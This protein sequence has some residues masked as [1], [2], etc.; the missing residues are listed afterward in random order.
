MMIC[1]TC[2]TARN[3]CDHE[4]LREVPRNWRIPR[5]TNLLA[6]RRIAKGDIMWDHNA[7][8]R[9]AQRNT[10]Y[11]NDNM[12]RRKMLAREIAPNTVTEDLT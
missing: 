3:T 4:D 9:K 10:S 12:D 5:K 2:R 6:W 7:I 1:I 11:R 8:T